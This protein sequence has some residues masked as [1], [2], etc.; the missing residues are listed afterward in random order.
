MI[1][2]SISFSSYIFCQSNCCDDPCLK[3][4]PF[5]FNGGDCVTAIEKEKCTSIY[6]KQTNTQIFMY[7]CRCVDII[8]QFTDTFDYEVQLL[9]YSTPWVHE[10]ATRWQQFTFFDF[11]TAYLESFIVYFVLGMSYLVFGMVY[12]LW[13]ILSIFAFNMEFL[14]PAIII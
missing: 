9:M 1:R 4:H 5:S 6:G 11:G 13:L 12:L 7:P 10:F 8:F 3:N 2:C 14:T